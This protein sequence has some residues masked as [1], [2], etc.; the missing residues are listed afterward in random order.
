MVET[1]LTPKTRNSLKL[2]TFGTNIP[3]DPQASTV[4]I[5]LGSPN[6]ELCLRYAARSIDAFVKVAIERPIRSSTFSR[7]TTGRLIQARLSVN[8]MPK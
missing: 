7:R 1:K 8:S 5:C 2:R 3:N 6:V 4:Q